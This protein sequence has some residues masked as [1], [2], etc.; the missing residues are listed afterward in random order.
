MCELYTPPQIF[1]TPQTQKEKETTN[2][3][4]GKRR[5]FEKY[6]VRPL[7]ELL[8]EEQAQEEIADIQCHTLANAVTMTSN[9]VENCSESMERSGTQG[10]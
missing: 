3:G 2:D 6:W 7:Q 8:I 9:D 10:L 5:S 4:R 1:Q